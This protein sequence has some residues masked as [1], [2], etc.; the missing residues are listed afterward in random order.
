MKRSAIKRVRE[1]TLKRV[2]G[3]ARKA[4]RRKARKS[5][6]D[7]DDPKYLALVRRL[8]C[9]APGYCGYCRPIR[10]FPIEA[11]H[12]TGAGMG[13]KADDRDTMPLCSHH[14]R[15]LHNFDG[16]FA[17]WPRE[18]RMQWQLAMIEETR[19]KVRKLSQER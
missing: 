5:R 18:R 19:E 11:H 13:R 2:S 7:A 3:L 6:G 17:G 8:P 4:V 1:G 15:A 14:H 12:L 16:P 9:C 10:A